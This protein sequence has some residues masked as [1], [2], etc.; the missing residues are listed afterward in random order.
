M[1]TKV[2]REV[3]LKHGGGEIN[4]IRKVIKVVIMV[5][6]LGYLIIW[7]LMP[8]NLYKTNWKV[9]MTAALS[10]AYFG[11]Q[12]YQLLIYTF[13]ILFIAA[14][15]SV[16]L[17][18]GKNCI[19]YEPRKEEKSGRWLARLRR[20]VLVRQPLG[21][22]SGI[23]LSFLMMF[24]AFFVWT[25]TMYLHIGY[26]NIKV[27]GYGGGRWLYKWEATT[28]RLG[29][30][31]NICLSLL[32]YPVTRGSSILQLFG[33]TS[34]GSIKYH[35]WLGH[36]T[37]ATFTA[38]G[39]GYIPL[40]AVAGEINQ[41]LKW[42]KTGVANV[43]GEISLL[44]GLILWAATFPKIRRK[45]F[46]V[47]FYTHYLYILFVVFFMFHVGIGYALYMLPGFYLFMIDRYLRFL[48][49][50]QPVR[51]LSARSLA[52]GALE[53]NFAK[54]R[55]LCYN[56]TSIMFLN[57][58]SVSKLQWHPFTIS[59]SANLDQ[60][61][62]S[63]V[64]K[65]EGSWSRKLYDLINSSSID[66]LQVSVEGPYGPASSHFLRHDTLVMVSG[67][68]GITPFMSI[69][70]ELVYVSTNFKTP[71]PKVLLISSFKRSCD[72]SM[73]NLILP[74]SG[75]SCDL[76]SLD[77]QIKAYITKDKVPNED[78]SN[79]P[80]TIWFKPNA[81]DSPISPSLGTN[82]WLWLGAI[83]MSS[84]VMFLILM[85]LL[86]RYYIYPID[87]NTNDIFPS[88]AKTIYYVLILC[89]CMVLVAS[90]AFLWNKKKNAMENKKIVHMEGITPTATPESRFYNADRELESLP[91]QSILESTEV[92][93]GGRPDLKKLLFD[94]KGSS[95]GVLVSGPRGLR[96]E[97]AAICGSGLVDN[98]HFESISFSW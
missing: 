15:G 83:I 61:K 55:S 87:H 78:V 62:L 53:L 25:L 54:S 84:F 40:W 75:S 30:T 21:I 24:I 52:C 46:E 16:Y 72:L 65:L 82:S 3:Q 90:A 47:F 17:H 70:Q 18:L 86:T 49:S 20:P 43:A 26:A 31:G 66:R 69:I 23:E 14:L 96:H 63:V 79:Q 92:H 73:L 45:Y 98:L 42:E 51:L 91:H 97:V 4:E 57:V 36:L 34:E 89:G 9:K 28:L 33:L 93:Y 37:M 74:L 95:V 11:T 6:I 29:L 27:Q 10:S 7:C 48:Q 39:L 64:I 8:T 12:G 56:P 44:C 81:S 19:E 22:V 2:E 94:C 5:V 38:H 88:A 50:S 60:D 41:A 13:P 76:S 80:R 68:S 1:D 32:F 35:I 77:L 59:S 85:G 71:T 58:P 67:G